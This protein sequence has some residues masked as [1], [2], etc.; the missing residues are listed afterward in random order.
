[1]LAETKQDDTMVN[2]L[3]SKLVKPEIMT[4]TEWL[5]VQQALQHSKDELQEELSD[6]YHDRI[7]FDDNK[8]L[9]KKRLQKHWHEVD[10][11]GSS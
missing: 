4:D 1:M 7:M 10:D 5:E 3:D 8:Y 9:L 2:I 11:C 6:D